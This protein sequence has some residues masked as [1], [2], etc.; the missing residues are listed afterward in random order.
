MQSSSSEKV[1]LFRFQSQINKCKC[2]YLQT[3]TGKV[4]VTPTTD[5]LLIWSKNTFMFWVFFFF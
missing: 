1:E 5:N 3:E 4:T 2:S